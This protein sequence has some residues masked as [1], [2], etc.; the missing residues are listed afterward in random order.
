MHVLKTCRHVGAPVFV[1]LLSAGPT[2]GCSRAI[3]PLAIPGSSAIA[4][5]GGADTLRALVVA[6]HTPGSAA[7]LFRGILFLG[8]AVTCSRRSGFRAAKRGFSDDTRIAAT[9]LAQL[10]SRLPAGSVRF[11]CT[12]HAHCA[13]I[14]ERFVSDVAR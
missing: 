3:V 2:T 5:T 14:D 4:L 1:A 8:D 9:S 12:A 13:P 6:G 11:V 7:Y 10:W